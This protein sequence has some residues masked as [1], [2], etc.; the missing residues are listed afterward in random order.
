MRGAVLEDESQILVPE[1]RDTFSLLPSEMG[2]ENLQISTIKAMEKF[3][4]DRIFSAIDIA[5]AAVL[6]TNEIWIVRQA[7]ESSWLNRYYPRAENG[8]RPAS[9]EP[10]RALNCASSTKLDQEERWNY[11][12]N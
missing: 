5:S 2:Y 6:I 7:K 10:E 9:V 8:I 1:I 3:L 12:R 4:Q 11:K